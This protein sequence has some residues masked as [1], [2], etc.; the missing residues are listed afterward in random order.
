MQGA[1]AESSHASASD[2]KKGSRVVEAS[3]CCLSVL[4]VFHIFCWVSC[5]TL[6]IASIWL[7]HQ[8]TTGVESSF[9][10]LVGVSIWISTPFFVSG[11]LSIISST[12]K[13]ESIV[14]WYMVCNIISLICSFTLVIFHGLAV[15]QE[16]FL[17]VW[18][19]R[20]IVAGVTA[21]VG[22]VQ[23]VT[24]SISI[25]VCFAAIGCTKPKIQPQNEVKNKNKV[26]PAAQDN[27]VTILTMQ[28][29]QAS[30]ILLNMHRRSESGYRK[31]NVEYIQ[32][33]MNS[34]AD[35]HHRGTESNHR[36]KVKMKRRSKRKRRA[37]IRT[38][39]RKI[40]SSRVVYDSTSS[41]SDEYTPY[42]NNQNARYQNRRS[43]H[44][45]AEPNAEPTPPTSEQ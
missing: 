20:I 31:S 13:N 41:E 32:L 24:S 8:N 11:V 2:I 21:G 4:A 27:V 25:I 42:N 29:H 9:M 45:N 3:V 5:V 36:H 15:A 19:K 35:Y 43:R 12:T 37:S 18:P 34:R 10:G 6:G 44:A 17:E 28:P 26:V 39:K 40:S 38:Q 30:E 16:S 23:V 1:T 7:R 14:S 22:I 33:D